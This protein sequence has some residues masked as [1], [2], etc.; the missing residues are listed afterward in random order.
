MTFYGLCW[1]LALLRPSFW[2]RLFAAEEA[3]WD[4]VRTGNEGAL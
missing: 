3:S 1:L 2:R 4:A